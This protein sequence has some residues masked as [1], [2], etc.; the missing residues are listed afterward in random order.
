MRCRGKTRAKDDGAGMGHGNS[1]EVRSTR[2]RRL[3]PAPRA[4]VYETLLDRTALALWKVPD[5]MNLKVH[6]WDARE[7]GSIRVSLTYRDA[8]SVGKSGAHTD[9]YHGQFVH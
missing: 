6:E 8:G 3:I 5:G 2:L 4:R 7:G 9:T 1:T